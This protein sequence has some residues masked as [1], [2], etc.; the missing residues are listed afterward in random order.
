MK[1]PLSGRQVRTLRLGV[2]VL[3]LL[4][5]GCASEAAQPELVP[6]DSASGP[7]WTAPVLALEDC[8]GFRP[9]DCFE[10]TVAVDG[11]GRIFVA[12]EG[13]DAFARSQD[14]GTTFERISSPPLPPQVPS[15]WRRG[16]V[17]LQLD[18][19]D[20]LFYSALVMDAPTFPQGFVTMALRGVQVARSDDG[21]ATW[22][23]NT[24]IGPAG[25]PPQPAPSVDRQWLVFDPD[26]E[27]LYLHSWSPALQRGQVA[28]S[29]DGGASFGPATLVELR[30]PAGPG[31]APSP[32]VLLI[33]SMEHQPDGHGVVLWKSED[34]ARTFSRV[35]IHEESGTPGYP[36]VFLD[37]AADKSVHASWRGSDG[38]VLVAT[39]HDE[40]TTWSEPVRWNFADAM[41]PAPMLHAHDGILDV[42]WFERDDATG[43]PGQRVVLGRAPLD[44]LEEGPALRSIIASFPGQDLTSDFAAFASAQGRTHV[45]WTQPEGEV[46]HTRETS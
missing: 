45:V 42:V 41:D 29:D 21:G 4:L 10:P 14:N 28:R 20:R 40:G 30:A 38:A 23:V 1:H 35:L 9:V 22:A 2:V 12:A 16:D 3:A 8:A 37:A 31:V 27:V 13:S 43:G 6:E 24:F 39:S 15:S 44:A 18:P 46:L 7:G 26:G 5:T 33:P 32:G 34:D 11:L 25:A 36:L 17:T 19:H